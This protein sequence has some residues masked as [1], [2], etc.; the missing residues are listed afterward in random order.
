MVKVASSIPQAPRRVQ[1]IGR[2]GTAGGAAVIGE[3]RDS[4]TPRPHLG[5]LF[6][7]R[8]L[9]LKGGGDVGRCTRS[10]TSQIDFRRSVQTRDRLIGPDIDQ[11]DTAVGPGPMPLQWSEK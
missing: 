3:T 4:N 1:L 11:T 7:L 8:L 2:G 5:L 6:F 9:Q 10:Q